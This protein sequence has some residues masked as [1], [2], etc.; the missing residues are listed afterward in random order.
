MLSPFRFF[1]IDSF[2]T[3]CTELAVVRRADLYVKYGSP[4][5]DSEL[6]SHNAPTFKAPY[7]S[8]SNEEVTFSNPPS[9][10]WYI[11]AQ[12][13]SS[14]STYSVTASCQGASCAAAGGGGGGGGGGADGVTQVLS[15]GGT[16][17]GSGQVQTHQFT[18]PANSSIR[19]EIA[20]GL[21]SIFEILAPGG[22]HVSLPSECCGGFFDDGGGQTTVAGSI[23]LTQGGTYTIRVKGYGS[24]TG[25]YSVTVTRL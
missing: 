13:Y 6:G 17:I 12:G 5:G 8:G 21:D 4:V 11:R 3:D 20:G 10:T 23:L 25:S 15:T 24:S 7:T 2:A 9:G 14:A 19:V 16:I 22:S 1:I 18:V